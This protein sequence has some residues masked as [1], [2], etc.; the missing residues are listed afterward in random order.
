VFLGKKRLSEM[1]GI[2]YDKKVL[3]REKG[4]PGGP[5]NGLA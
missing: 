1:A 5:G 2:W 4:V 3:M